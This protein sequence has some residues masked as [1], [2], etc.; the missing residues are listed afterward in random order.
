[1]RAFDSWN[2]YLDNDGNL[3]HGKI[4]FCKKG[5]TTDI[6][7]Y[8]RDGIAIRNPEFTD[9][10]GRTEYQVF[11]ENVENVTAYFY[12]YIGSDDMMRWPS[13]DYDPARWALQY[14]SDN[15]D[16]VNI[17][18]ITAST[19]DGV[20]TMQDLRG[21]DPAEV[22]P[23]DG[24]KLIWVYGYYAAGDTSPV[25]YVWDSASA[26]PDDGGACIQANA[27][28]GNGRWILATRELHFDVRHFGVFPTDDIY[29]TDYQYTSQLANCAAYIDSE[30]L[31]AWFPAL[32]DNLSYYL[33]NGT[34]TFSIKGDIYVSDNVRMHAKTGTNGTVIQC[35]ELHKRTPYLFVSTQ[36]TGLVTLRADWVNISWV[37]GMVTGDA[38]I[39]WVIDSSSFAR[40]ITGK[41]VRFETNGSASLV[42]DNCQVTSNEKI[43]GDITIQNSV[44]DTDW[45][46]PDYNWANLTSY[47]N[48]ILLDNCRDADTY[49]TLKNKQSEA[50][51]G[52]L[53]EQT[54][55]GKTL[56]AGALVEN[57]QFAGV[58]IQ[59]ATELHNVS[60]TVTFSGSAVDGNFIDC[61]LELASAAT[62]AGMTW[63][64]GTLSGSKLTVIGDAY[65][66]SIVFDA[67][68]E[69]VGT[70]ALRVRDSQ[71][72]VG[73]KLSSGDLDVYGTDIWGTVEAKSPASVLKGH[74]CT[75]R[76]LGSGK[77]AISPTN[78]SGAEITPDV[79]MTCNF[80]D[81]NFFDDSQFNGVVHTVGAGTF[82]YRDNYGG[83]P[84]TEA[85]YIQNIGYSLVRLQD[86]EDPRVIPA[87]TDN[88]VKLIEDWRP[89]LGDTSDTVKRQIWWCLKLNYSFTPGSNNM[90]VPAY[91]KVSRAF[92]FMPSCRCWFQNGQYGIS[93]NEFPMPQWV[94]SVSCDS[95]TVTRAATYTMQQQVDSMYTNSDIDEKRSRLTV[96]LSS[97]INPSGWDPDPNAC[98]T[99]N[100]Y[101]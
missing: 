92:R 95:P 45:F 75:N 22:P 66:D 48:T 65:L 6:I 36:Q 93:A 13:E 97:A 96:L 23:V 84:V 33:F 17:V 100:I 40:T 21:K 91:F 63:R 43:T 99:W 86:G 46:A 29:S 19:A 98:I 52:D 94:T 32:S 44:L 60:G 41:E 16:P 18:D 12:Q 55:T 57:A 38:R 37:G 74:V 88:T 28:P 7:I 5:T 90:F 62:A 10:L 82:L 26:A 78:M 101:S 3:L 4:R 70:S 27:V 1:M 9:R 39:G 20:A 59:G 8:N 69:T 50:D 34:N 2:S 83:C 53:G 49:I 79:V 25:L 42:L 51:Y 30:G 71:V 85:H 56:L 24:A 68:V 87:Q 35:H 15:L 31:D 77:F 47:Q 72:A 11:V 76:F 54:V 80:S 61:W 81:H 89:N 58:T 67:D 64:R 73:K 14:T